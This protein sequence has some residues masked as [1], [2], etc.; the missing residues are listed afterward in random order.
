M[1]TPTQVVAQFVTHLSDDRPVER[2][3]ADVP[4]AALDAAVITPI[5]SSS[6]PSTHTLHPVERLGHSLTSAGRSPGAHRRR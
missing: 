4:A 5:S 6:G 3:F 1:D 2:R